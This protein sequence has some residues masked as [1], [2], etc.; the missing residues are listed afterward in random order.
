MD[1]YPD[2]FR[3]HEEYFDKIMGSSKIREALLKGT[4]VEDIIKSYTQ[5]LKAFDKIRKPYLIY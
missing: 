4:G 5:E 3:F 1:S 2:E